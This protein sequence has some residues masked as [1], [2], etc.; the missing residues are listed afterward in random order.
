[1]KGKRK[2]KDVRSHEL[3]IEGSKEIRDM[4]RAELLK[5]WGP[6]KCLYAALRPIKGKG[7][8]SE[9]RSRGTS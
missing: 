7:Y 9:G 2:E 3:H 5:Q 1:M 6:E 4:N 8:E